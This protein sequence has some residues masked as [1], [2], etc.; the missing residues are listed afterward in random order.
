MVGGLCAGVKVMYRES[1]GEGEKERRRR[2]SKKESLVSLESLHS[3]LWTHSEF[4]EILFSGLHSHQALS[5]KG[6]M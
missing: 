1:R 2:R 3:K 5:A 6:K 4:Q